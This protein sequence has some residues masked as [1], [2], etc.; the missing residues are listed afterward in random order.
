MPATTTTAVAATRPD[1]LKTVRHGT[2]LDST[3]KTVRLQSAAL[4]GFHDPGRLRRASQDGA[5]GRWF[6]ARMAAISRSCLLHIHSING[7]RISTLQGCRMSR[8][9]TGSWPVEKVLGDTSLTIPVTLPASF[10]LSLGESPPFLPR[11]RCGSA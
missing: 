8:A 9:S 1:Q 7:Q 10:Y 5:P 2:R 4:P 11:G 3:G 6:R